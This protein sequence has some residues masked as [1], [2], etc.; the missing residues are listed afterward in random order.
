M[1]DTTTMTYNFIVQIQYKSSGFYTW[2]RIETL[3]FFI[4]SMLL[5]LTHLLTSV[6]ISTKFYVDTTMS[7]VIIAAKCDLDHFL[8]EVTGFVRT[9]PAY[10]SEHF[11]QVL[12]RYN[13]K[14]WSYGP[15]KV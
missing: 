7:C 11:Y 3:T 9:M 2:S 8:H 14:S 15:D 12:W 4:F 10:E 5:Y 13:N 1:I 6:N